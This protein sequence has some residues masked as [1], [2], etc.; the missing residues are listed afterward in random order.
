MGWGGGEGAYCC[1]I[2]CDNPAAVRPEP[3]GCA[4]VRM[5]NSSLASSADGASAEAIGC[6]PNANPAP[7]G[8]TCACDYYVLMELAEIT[9]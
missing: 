9:R 6:A 5:A 2:T 4:A 7:A 1:R 8:P 3:A